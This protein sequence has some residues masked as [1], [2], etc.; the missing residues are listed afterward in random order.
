MAGRR[1]LSDEP[2]T[3]TCIPLMAQM[4][5]KWTFVAKRRLPGITPKAPGS[6]CPFRREGAFSTLNFKGRCPWPHKTA[7]LKRFSAYPRAGTARLAPRS[8][9]RSA[10]GSSRSAS[11]PDCTTA[12]REQAAIELGPFDIIQAPE[13]SLEHA[14]CPHRDRVSRTQKGASGG[15][16]FEKKKCRIGGFLSENGNIPEAFNGFRRELWAVAWCERW[17]DRRL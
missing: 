16:I 14:I 10:K 4:R 5:T 13:R 2:Q 7:P 1:P 3:F 12:S 15:D 8:C 17:L 11:P 6:A 9:P